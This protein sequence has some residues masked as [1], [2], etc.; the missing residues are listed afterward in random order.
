MWLDK[1]PA[2]WNR[3]VRDPIGFQHTPHFRKMM[4]L[5]SRLTHVLDDVVGDNYVEHRIIVGKVS[6]IHLLEPVT[7]TGHT[8]V[9]NIY[10]ANIYDQVRM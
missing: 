5:R 10:G 1:L 6:P 9:C 4:L 8:V 7:V 2:I 3:Q